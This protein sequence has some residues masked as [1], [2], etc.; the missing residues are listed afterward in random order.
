[1]AKE[2]KNLTT[3]VAASSQKL[4]KLNSRQIK[5]CAYIEY[6]LADK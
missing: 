3:A 6:K 5:R 1:M 4:L 2:A